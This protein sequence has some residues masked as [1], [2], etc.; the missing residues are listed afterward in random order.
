MALLSKNLHSI[1][2]TPP[3]QGIGSRVAAQTQAQQP[4]Q[5]RNLAPFSYGPTQQLEM[6]P[7][8]TPSKA[9]P[10]YVP[11]RQEMSAQAQSQEKAYRDSMAELQ[12]LQQQREKDEQNGTMGSSPYQPQPTTPRPVQ[13]PPPVQPSP[14]LIS[15][16]Q[17]EARAAEKA[18]ADARMQQMQQQQQQR[19]LLSQQREKARQDA[20]IRAQAQKD[21]RALAERKRQDAINATRPQPQPV[22]PTPQPVQSTP[23]G[24]GNFN[25]YGFDRP[26][27]DYLNNQQKLST[28]DA[29]ISYSY[30]P[31]TQ[32]FTGGARG[33]PIKK[34]LQEM[35]AEQAQSKTPAAFAQPYKKGGQ[36]KSAQDTKK[37]YTSGGKI[38]LNECS[39]STAQ[40]GKTNSNW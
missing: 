19:L 5:G 38:N 7:T 18:K 11:T 27:L 1:F 37:K 16:R 39:V 14:N 6:G 3:A 26:L 32:T 21:A 10:T 23:S 34:T 40:K 25:E 22:Q 2:S 28:I 35:Q 24:Y 20:Q 17:A 13:P 8:S 15:Q 33:G 4:Q 12:R 31:A 30:D 36:V 29:G 9:T